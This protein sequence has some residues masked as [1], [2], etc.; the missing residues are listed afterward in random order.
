M[1]K[2]VAI[3]GNSLMYRAY[4][5]L[6]PM[7]NQSGEPTQAVYGFVSML[8]KVLEM[9]EVEY[10]AVAFDEKG[11]TFRHKQYDAYKAGRKP[12]PEDLI[13]Q[14]PLLKELLKEMGIQTYSMEGY[15]ADDILGGFAALA[16]RNG[17]EA[18]LVTGDRDALQLIS[19]TT[20]VLLTKKGISETTECTVE[21]LKEELGL[22]PGQIIDLKALMGDA[23][24]NIPGIAGVGE[25]TALKLLHEYGTVE[26]VLENAANIKGKMGEKIA[27][28]KEAALISKQLATIDSAVPIEFDLQQV[29]FTWPEA[30]QIQEA[31]LK[32]EFKSL[33]QKI[34][35]HT[36]AG[37]KARPQEQ[38]STVT[39]D[40][41]DI[42]ALRKL[43]QE[44]Q[45]ELLALHMGEDITLCYEENKQYCIKINHTLLDE[46]LSQTDV[47]DALREALEKAPKVAFDVKSLLHDLQRDGIE[48]DGFVFDIMLAA[49]VLQPTLKNEIEP[50]CAHFGVVF[51]GAATLM[52]LYHAFTEQMER[53][54]LTK[55]FDEIEMPL[56]DVLYSMERQG[57]LVDIE[58][59]QELSSQYAQM[60]DDVSKSVYALCGQTFNIA[61][62][63]QL[64][65]VLFEDLGLKS[66]KKTKTGYSTDIEVLESLYEEHSVIPLI[67]RYRQLTKLKST[68]MDALIQLAKKDRRIY[69]RFHQAITA[70]GRIS[71]S[72]PNL[73]NIPVRTEEGREIRKLFVAP[74]GKVIVDADYS[75][76]EL[77]ILAHMAGD[78]RMIGAFLAGEDIHLATAAEVFGV[79]ASMVTPAMR[80]SAKAVNFG[81]VYGISDFGLGK[82][83]HI[84]RHKAGGYIKRYFERYTGVKEYMDN[85]VE[86]GKRDGYVTT[87][88]G[89]RRYLPELASKNYN[90][91]QFGERVAMNMPI[92]GTAADI[93]KIAMIEVYNRLQAEGYAARL[94]LQVHDELLIEAP[95]NECEAVMKLLQECMENV[96]QLKVPLIAEVRYGK[97]WYDAK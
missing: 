23:S 17:V 44:H 59:L 47:L 45:G 26:N 30:E 79:P 64:G 82:N 16:E 74:E 86:Q 76:I 5:A 1:G 60:I 97:S 33:F 94:I 15:E 84:S 8:L 90:M 36:L 29:K 66:V 56:L 19:D 73:Q 70:T 89:R 95:E 22:T 6:P 75:Q 61:S 65:V 48:A 63:K 57:F 31:F 20:H 13:P 37:N 18:L 42:K 71:S 39:E 9:F 35:G 25:K 51:E 93:I 28:G 10:L 58:A 2:L 54:G 78:E 52:H 55:L 41:A 85:I 67:I 4:Y 68:Y 12:T 83:L 88:F 50:I 81:I 27:N 11:K 21:W 38:I 24:D 34:T 49:Y 96:V 46:G 72:D 14:F 32:L 87:L 80:S 77:R 43:L 62:P 92:Q 7:N 53:D 91:R 40:I 69:T 3:D